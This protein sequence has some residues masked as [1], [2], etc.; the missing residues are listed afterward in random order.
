MKDSNGMVWLNLIELE[1]RRSDWIKSP[2]DPL[3]I[4]NIFRHLSIEDNEKVLHLSVKGNKT[5]PFLAKQF[6]G[7]WQFSEMSHEQLV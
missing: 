2:A 5:V 4:T 7:G 6:N 1:S 3:S